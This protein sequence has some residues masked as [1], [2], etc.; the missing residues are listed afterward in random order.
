MSKTLKAYYQEGFEQLAALVKQNQSQV[1]TN[2]EK[3]LNT[4][5]A[6]DEL[7]AEELELYLAKNRWVKNRRDFND[8]IITSEG[9]EVVVNQIA[10]SI[11]AKLSSLRKKIKDKDLD[12]PTKDCQLTDGV[13]NYLEHTGAYARLDW[14]KTFLAR[15]RC[16]ARIGDGNGQ[17]IGSGLLIEGN[18]LLTTF[19]LLPDAERVAGLQIKVDFVQQD[20]PA[21][22]YS[23]L[24]QTWKANSDLNIVTVEVAEP[25]SNWNSLPP[26]PTTLKS[27]QLIF[28]ISAGQDEPL[29]G[30]LAQNRLLQYQGAFLFGEDT[31]VEIQSGTP[32]FDEGGNWLGMHHGGESYQATTA[33]AVDDFLQGTL[34]EEDP[35]PAEKQEQATEI[36][37]HKRF[38]EHHQYACNRVEHYDRFTAYIDLKEEEM[39]RDLH[40]FY[41][42]GG[43]LQAH[44]GLYNRFVAKL[45][46]TDQDHISITKVKN[47]V[48]SKI[49]SFPQSTRLDNLKLQL[50]VRV[51]K[52]F[53]L[54]EPQIEKIAD[55]HLSAVLN[56]P[57]S[58][59]YQW[60]KA[61]KVCLLIGVE[62]YVWDKDLTPEIATWFIEEF[63]QKALPEN[64]PEFFIFFAI[65]YEDEE[66]D[67]LKTEVLE[68]LGKGKYINHFFPELDMVQPRD[69]KAWFAEYAVYWD[70]DRKAMRQTRKRHF[71]ELKAP[72][73]MEDVQ[74]I[75]EEVIEEINDN[76]TK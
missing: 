17:V 48:A 43:E 72:Q 23:L 4:L 21:P 33:S 73:Y 1:T 54:E 76:N 25:L 55:K 9:H 32:L 63:C 69:V 5:I 61:D 19:E 3:A 65:Y 46:G 14:M 62:E 70:H 40:F 66:D 37:S 44:V 18:R 41:L 60:E 28:S 42:H 11:L 53:G 29:R 35:A 26:V 50:P 34:D 22:I 56:F 49:I 8:K 30:Q 68:A 31:S 52:T 20:E 36:L 6:Y 12:L 47:R 67:E 51:L 10:K 75:L 45:E 13:L 64:S 59:V 58:I 2:L 7:L 74:D 57:G 38:N 24:P 15:S 27:N 71:G 16:V 39:K